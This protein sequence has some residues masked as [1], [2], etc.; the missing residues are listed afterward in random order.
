[1]TDTA[2]S[3]PEHLALATLQSVGGYTGQ[4]FRDLL[5]S[6]PDLR[7]WVPNF[8]FEAIPASMLGGNL[9]G[10]NAATITF[11]T[12]HPCPWGMNGSDTNHY[13]RISGGTGTAEARLITGG[14]AVAGGTSGTITFTPTNSHSGAYTVTSASSGWA[15]QITQYPTLVSQLPSG[16]VSLYAT[17]TPPNTWPGCAGQGF[18]NTIIAANFTGATIIA[19][20]STYLTFRDFLIL[21]S[22]GTMT[23][24]SAINCSAV[25]LVQMH[26]VHLGAGGATYSGL[27]MAGGNLIASGCQVV[28]EFRGFA[29]TDTSFEISHTYVIGN[30]VYATVIAN[31]AALFLAG[32]ITSG[33][34]YGFWHS[35]GVYAYGILVD[36]AS[37]VNEVN[38]AGLYLD[39]WSV[40]G[41]SVSSTT[42]A[43]VHS[44]TLS[45]FRIVDNVQHGGYCLVLAAA[46]VGWKF[47]PGFLVYADGY[48][49][50]ITGS[51]TDIQFNG[52]E[53]EPAIVAAG[54]GVVVAGG[55]PARI[56]L[57]GCQIG[58]GQS[59]ALAT[60]TLGFFSSV[61]IDYLTIVGCTI[62]ATTQV[63]KIHLAGTETHVKIANNNGI[64][65]VRKTVAAA[66]TLT[67][68]LMDDEDVIEITG[69]TALATAVAGLREGQKITMVWT[70]AAPGAV[71]QVATIASPGFTPTRYKA[72]G[73]MFSNGKLY[74]T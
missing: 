55:T 40:A 7:T 59:G 35:A 14:T 8:N 54:G 11:T 39:N 52:T 31:S 66:A 53:I 13:I 33:G 60:S 45:S 56:T 23:T 9:T 62:N 43:A 18:F 15:E 20:S 41:I 51:A 58:I 34:L 28:A 6:I 61:A 73:S 17:L 71:S 21:P 10:G 69:A 5:T 24:G 74:F 22:A 50:Y 64:S 19:A 65:D 12:A 42:A 2:R 57:N 16:T 70:D 72:Y 46:A 47:G 27:T 26:H 44:W 3:Q 1:M 67:F 36:P 49:V 63:E 29:L 30:R 48:G 4:D 38:I 32:A 68:P 25:A 37:A